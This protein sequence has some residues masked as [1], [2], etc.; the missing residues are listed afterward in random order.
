MAL[1]HAEVVRRDG[2]WQSDGLADLDG[3]RA[4]GGLQLPALHRGAPCARHN[5]RQRQQKRLAV[6]AEGS[7]AAEEGV[8]TAA[9]SSSS[10][11]VSTSPVLPR[12]QGA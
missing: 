5:Q 4:R 6:A 8:P 3:A 2:C 10:C 12:I 7:K 11:S 9:T 1:T